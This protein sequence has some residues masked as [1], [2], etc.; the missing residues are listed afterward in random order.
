MVALSGRFIER[1]LKARFV[2]LK[3]MLEGGPA[4]PG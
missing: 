4:A 1:D 3:S 2:A